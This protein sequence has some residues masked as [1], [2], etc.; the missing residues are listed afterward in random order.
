MIPRGRGGRGSHLHRGGRAGKANNALVQYGNMRLIASNI[1]ESAS[2]S[3]T[4]PGPNDPLYG[5]FLEFIKQKKGNTP[6]YANALVEEENEDPH[7]YCQSPNKE[8]IIFLEY[9]D[10]MRYFEAGNDP[11]ILMSRYLDNAPC[12]AY[13]YK[14]RSYYENILI[15]T[16]SIEVRHFTDQNSNIYNFSKVLIKQVISAEEWG[17]STLKEK[18]FIHPVQKITLKYNYWDYVESFYKTFLYINPKRKH[19][20]FFK[21]CQKMY[22]KS[23]PN[24]FI[25]WWI[26]YGPSIQIL[27]EIYKGLYVEWVGVSPKLIDMMTKTNGNK[28]IIPSL[29]F[30]IEFSI[31]WIWK[32]APEV[33]YASDQIPQLERVFFTKFWR[34]MLVK[35]P[36]NG[37]INS[38][39]TLDLIKRT[40]AEYKTQYEFRKKKENPTPYQHIVDKLKMQGKGNIS[41]EEIL[42]AY[43]E[44]VK[45]DLIK[46]FDYH[47]SDS[48]MK[49]LSE[50]ENPYNCLAGES[51]PDD[52]EEIPLE[53][54]FEE[55]KN[56]VSKRISKGESSI[57][58]QKIGE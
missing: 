17:L 56:T 3:S 36:E 30:F 21:V 10:V 31:P 58:K 7:E 13:A 16:G 42:E 37:E 5:E 39:E 47:K 33:N 35:N 8:R 22:N 20:W 53:D 28:E 49:D 41:K 38:K 26:S 40:I 6:S 25:N 52:T 54:I 4:I 12:A 57:G 29:L 19:S 24:W 44:E 1:A 48:S 43:L 14:S 45:D 32:W 55:I 18:E 11:W 51:Q 46:N 15:T 23:L 34:K 2:S 9:Q 27:P 50:D